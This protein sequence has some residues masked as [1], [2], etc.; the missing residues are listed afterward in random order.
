MTDEGKHLK[1]SKE[2]FTQS[3]SK[4]TKKP[5]D[6]KSA[7]TTSTVTKDISKLSKMVRP[8]SDPIPPCSQPTEEELTHLLYVT[9]CDFSAGIHGDLS[10]KRGELLYI[11]NSD[12][13]DWWL[14]ETKHSGQKGYVPSNYVVKYKSDL[15]TEISEM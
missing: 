15:D 5:Q 3:F 8:W 4:N 10:I 1:E 9:K 2:L 7:T 12:D 6:N 14:A 13:K 11:M